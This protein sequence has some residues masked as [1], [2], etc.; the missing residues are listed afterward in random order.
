MSIVEPHY[1]TTRTQ[2]QLIYNYTTTRKW[3]YNKLV[4]NI[5]NHV[6]N[7]Q[8]FILFTRLKINTRNVGICFLVAT[9]FV[10]KV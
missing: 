10:I 3:K 4:N 6:H 7:Y 1:F 5:N 2:K 9:Q 8:I